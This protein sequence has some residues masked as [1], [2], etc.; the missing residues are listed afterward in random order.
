MEKVH[1][2]V[3]FCIKNKSQKD[4]DSRQK[5]KYESR[6]GELRRER[7]NLLV[8]EWLELTMKTWISGDKKPKF[9]VKKGR[10][11]KI[12]QLEEKNKCSIG[13]ETSIPEIVKLKAQLTF[14]REEKFEAEKYRNTN[15][16]FL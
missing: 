12:W 10:N 5:K 6:A 8:K 4:L 11:A 9:R 15:W 1:S 2:W 14:P 3:S 7:K 13:P 16:V